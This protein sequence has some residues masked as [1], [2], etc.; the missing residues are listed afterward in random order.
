MFA[1]PRAGADRAWGEHLDAPDRA[2]DT[3]PIRDVRDDRECCAGVA[4]M[5]FATS[6]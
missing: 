1:E 6:I 4:A 2:H 3:G 5:D